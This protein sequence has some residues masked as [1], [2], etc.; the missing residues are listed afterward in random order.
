MLGKSWMPMLVLLITAL[1]RLGLR[2]TSETGRGPIFRST[3]A[4]PPS[5]CYAR[6]LGSPLH[7]NCTSLLASRADHTI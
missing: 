2:F 7:C 1:Q 5:C 4:S 6:L 3:A